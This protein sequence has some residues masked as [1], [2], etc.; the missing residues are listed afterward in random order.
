LGTTWEPGC[1]PEAGTN[2]GDGKKLHGKKIEETSS[3]RAKAQSCP[4]FLPSI[5]CHPPIPQ[6]VRF[7]TRLQDLQDGSPAIADGLVILFIL[8]SCL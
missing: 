6:S 7:R 3:G 4:M 8:A 2:N 1:E 5:F